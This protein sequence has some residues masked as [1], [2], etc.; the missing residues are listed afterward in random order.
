M[1][2]RAILRTPMPDENDADAE[3]V[4][5]YLITLLAAVWREADQFSG[6][7]P[8]GNSGWKQDIA[9]ALIVAGHVAGRLDEDGC[10]DDLDD[11]A[12]DRMVRSAIDALRAVTRD[13]AGPR[14]ATPTE[15]D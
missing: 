7:R 8:F 10:V 6:K 9:K 15:G 1:D 14:R 12:A 4:G 3:T 13:E 11:E 2:A 5:D